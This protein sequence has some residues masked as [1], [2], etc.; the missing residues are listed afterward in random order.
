MGPCHCREHSSMLG[1]WFCREGHYSRGVGV[2]DHATVEN[3]VPCWECRFCREGHYSR[4]VGVW[5]HA[6]VENIV[7]CWGAGSV[8][9]AIIVEG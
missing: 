5:D 7:P 6:T 3:I 4:G 1:C 2:W 8:G 9:R